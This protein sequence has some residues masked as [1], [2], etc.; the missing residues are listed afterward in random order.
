MYAKTDICCNPRHTLSPLQTLN[1]SICCKL[2]NGFQHRQDDKFYLGRR[3][4]SG[5]FGQV[6][7]AK[8]RRGKELAVKVEHLCSSWCCLWKLL[9]HVDIVW[10]DGAVLKDFGWEWYRVVTCT[11]LSQKVQRINVIWAEFQWHAN[12]NTG[13]DTGVSVTPIAPP[14]TNMG[15]WTCR[16]GKGRE[17]IQR[18][19][20]PSWVP[21]TNLLACICLYFSFWGWLAGAPFSF[22]RLTFWS[23]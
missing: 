9:Q 11:I 15:P 20:H 16:L 23:D 3:L 21:S 14:K 8:N 22:Q 6:F 17:S 4:G 12:S 2:A 10:R 18:S 7:L 1:L 5:S 19:K 13:C